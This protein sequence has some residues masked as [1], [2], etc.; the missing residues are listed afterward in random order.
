MCS[1]NF[2]LCALVCL[3]F[4]KDSFGTQYQGI[5]SAICERLLMPSVGCDEQRDG[6]A[7]YFSLLA[8]SE[9]AIKLTAIILER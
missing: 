7:M 2:A 5:I 9:L 4:F 3:H 1:C 8:K 6:K